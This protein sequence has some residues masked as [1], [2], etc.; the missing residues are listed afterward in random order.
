MKIA[1]YIFLLL[2]LASVAFTVFIATHDGKYEIKQ[3]KLIKVPKTSL[4]NYINDYTNWNTINILADTDSTTVYTY[5]TDKTIGKGAIANWNTGEREG[6]IQTVKTVK[7]DSI[8]QYA[9]T[10]NEKQEIIWT[11]KDTLNS[12]KISVRI[13]GKLTF[14]EKAY[15]IIR[16]SIENRAEAALKQGLTK[17][18]HFIEKELTTYNIMVMGKTIKTNNFYLGYTVTG[19]IENIDKNIIAVLPKL[20]DFIKTNRISTKGEPFVIYDKK[21]NRNT[22][23][24]IYTICIPIEEEIITSEGSEFEGGVLQSFPALKTT[25]KGD[26]L[27]LKKAWATSN[28]YIEEKALVIDT[29]R[30]YVE[31]YRN[32]LHQSK[33]PSEWI[34]DIY[35]PITITDSL[36]KTVILPN[37]RLTPVQQ[38]SR[39]EVEKT[40]TPASMINDTT[41]E[42]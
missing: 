40:S 33:N 21:Y 31:V 30:N 39:Q 15:A 20:L 23:K 26:Y 22:T 11:F 19:S 8:I 3:S 9:Y 42:N 17:M 32:G 6:E 5:P 14:T 29:T 12:T 4:Y 1:K 2:L 25:L 38:A 10:D 13:K 34:T 37:A 7:H 16:G 24:A 18:S 35:F 28:K 36:T 41:P 27:N